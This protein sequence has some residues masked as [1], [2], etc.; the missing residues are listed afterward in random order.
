MTGVLFKIFLFMLALAAAG[1]LIIFVFATV[2]VIRSGRQSSGQGD[3]VAMGEQ[4]TAV[5]TKNS[6]KKEFIK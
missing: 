2:R 5:L 4:V 1:V 3:T 6:G